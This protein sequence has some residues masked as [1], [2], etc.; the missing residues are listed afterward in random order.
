MVRKPS[1]P[2][3]SST[4]EDYLMEIYDMITD[5]HP[6]IAARLTDKMNVAAPTV[7]N[8]VHRMQRDG[9]VDIDEHS[10]EITLPA[11]GLKAAESIKRRHL[12][13][14]RLLVDILGLPWADAHEE[15]HLIEHTITPRVE[16][17]IMEVLGHPTTCPHGNPMP[18]LE[19]AM[20]PTTRPL[21]TAQA[22]EEWDLDGINE[23]AEEDHDLM[24]FYQRNGFVP[25][26]RVKVL[27]VAAYNSTMAVA[28]G[29][30]EVT[31]GMVAAENLR[32]VVAPPL[33]K[34]VLAAV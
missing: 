31:L 8:T 28:V 33:K 22:G 9:L 4:V 18:G 7:W 16:A 17:R 10:K 1:T 11:P 30:H 15:A 3:P 14:E 27:E 6:V 23:P 5:G 2:T 26:A 20:R 12:L 34:P 32:I 29:G 24:T 13:T 21:S 19:L 25:G